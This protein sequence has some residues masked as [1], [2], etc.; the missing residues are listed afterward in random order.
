MVLAAPLLF[1]LAISASAQR[2]CGPEDYVRAFGNCTQLDGAEGYREMTYAKKAGV[3]CADLAVNSKAELV[4]CLCQP[5]EYVAIYAMEGDQCMLSYAPSGGCQGTPSPTGTPASRDLCQFSAVECSSRHIQTTY[6]PCDYSS[7]PP[8]FKALY[9]YEECN[10]ELGSAKSR[11]P[12]GESIACDINCVGGEV[13]D[14]AACSQCPAGTYSVGGG[15]RLDSFGEWPVDV[16]NQ[17]SF[18]TLCTYENAKSLLPGTRSEC[19]GWEASGGKLTVGPY[20]A[21]NQMYDFECKSNPDADCHNYLSSA[22]QMQVRLVRDGALTFTYSVNAEN[23]FDGLQLFIDNTDEAIMPLTSYVYGTKSYTHPLTS[24]FHTIYWVY[25]KDSGWTAG[26]DTASIHSIEVNGTDRFAHTCQE[27]PPGY[28]SEA[29]AS[30]CT[31]CPRDFGWVAP[32][33]GAPARCQP[34]SMFNYTLEEPRVTC[35]ARPECVAAKDTLVTYG[36]CLS[37]TGATA[38][39]SRLRLKTHAWRE[40]RVCLGGEDTLPAEEAVDCPACHPGTFLSGGGTCKECPAGQHSSEETGYTA[41]VDCPAGTVA[42]RL[43]DTTGSM[44]Q[45]GGLPSFLSTLCEGNCGSPGWIVRTEECEAEGECKAWLESGSGHGRDATVWLQLNVDLEMPGELRL[46]YQIQGGQW[47]DFSQ[48]LYV[49]IDGDVVVKDEDFWMSWDSAFDRGRGPGEDASQPQEWSRALGEG[50]HVVQLAWV[51]E[52]ASEVPQ[53]GDFQGVMLTRFEVTSAGEGFGGAPGCVPV[54]AGHAAAAGSSRW[55]A[56][57]PGTFS[58]GG[59]AECS[60]CPEGTY[61][62]RP[63]QNSSACLACPPGTSSSTDRA[64]CELGGA[65]ASFCTYSP[66]G[67]PGVTFDIKA[68]A[69]G[70]AGGADPLS[71]GGSSFYVQ[72][73]NRTA[74]EGGACV[75]YE[76]E[77]LSTNICQEDEGSSS[78]RTERPYSFDAGSLITSVAAIRGN[79]GFEVTYTGQPGARGGCAAGGEGAARSTTVAFVCDPAAGTGEAMA[80]TQHAYDVYKG[81]GTGSEGRPAGGW[82]T[83]RTPGELRGLHEE[84][85]CHV[86]LVWY[87]AHACRV[88]TEDDYEEVQV[89]GCPP[90]AYTLTTFRWKAGTGRSCTPNAVSGASLPLDQACALCVEGDYTA[91]PSDCKDSN[92]HSNVTYTWVLP[93][94]CNDQVEG[95]ARLPAPVVAGPCEQ[96]GVT[97]EKVPQWGYAAAAGAVGLILLLIVCVIV[98]YIKQRKIYKEYGRLVALDIHNSEFKLEDEAFD[99][100]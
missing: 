33:A 64:S 20:D 23:G 82:P 50:S 78:A 16:G 22:L 39:Q 76:G 96:L 60:P 12:P 63:G 86:E 28:T 54:P 53:D 69:A 32:A 3:D 73:C 90:P 51:R 24:G 99:G 80:W 98:S 37:S 95:A 8:V 46:G 35:I 62:P 81:A 48:G 65:G 56:C 85:E 6:T 17:W 15:V 72:P 10:P 68:L 18:S 75:D 52:G 79:R 2:P 92:G 1:F 55:S 91:L 7:D 4:S 89:E 9:Y 47:D 30:A 94:R 74:H 38:E 59:A 58:D 71:Y 40:P 84:G 67:A 25:A 100:L 36:E 11:L 19:S 42:Q 43:L 77:P 87:T 13:L 29:G 97:E 49:Y 70:H 27:C 61:N 34:C 93:K 5:S 14:G 44:I 66:P 88:C 57:A 83:A 21:P 45:A 26:T 31:A 41:C